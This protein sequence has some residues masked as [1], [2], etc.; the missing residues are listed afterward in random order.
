[1]VHVP[2]GTDEWEIAGSAWSDSD[3]SN[4][5]WNVTASELNSELYFIRLFE[6]S[7][8][9]L[10]AGDLGSIYMQTYDANNTMQQWIIKD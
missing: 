9:A 6:D 1:M 4:F 10:A 7:N 5:K 2:T 3:S 8:Y